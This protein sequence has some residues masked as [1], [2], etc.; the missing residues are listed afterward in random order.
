VKRELEKKDQEL[1]EAKRALEELKAH[2][3]NILMAQGGE[4]TKN[5]SS[6][7][8]PGKFVEKVYYET[9]RSTAAGINDEMEESKHGGDLGETASQV[10]GHHEEVVEEE[11]KEEMQEMEEEVKEEAP[12]S[13]PEDRSSS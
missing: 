2:S 12:R 7:G 6:M 11:V 13:K 8:R 10:K 1:R 9:P 4:E 3:P 5:N